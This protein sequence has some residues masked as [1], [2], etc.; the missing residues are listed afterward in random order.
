M[1][2]IITPTF[3]R[4]AV[5]DFKA[6]VDNEANNYYIGIGKLTP[7]P[8]NPGE[9]GQ[10][11]VGEE[12]STFV[13]PLP[14]VTLN[15]EKDVRDEL[16]T[17]VKVSTDD[18]RAMIPKNQWKPNRKYKRY[19]PT[20]PLTFEYEG[21][22]FPCVSV[23][24]DRIY[25]CVAN[26][27]QQVAP[28]LNG[29]PADSLRAP[30]YDNIT[31]QNN[32]V[33]GNPANRVSIEDDNGYMWAYLGDLKSNSK[34]DNDQFVG[35]PDVLIDT[36]QNESRATAAKAA[37][38]GLIYGF[39]VIET[40]NQIP[41]TVDLVIEGVGEDGNALPN[42]DIIINGQ[43]QSPFVVN[44]LAAGGSSINEIKYSG[45]LRAAPLGYAKATVTAYGD[46]NDI[47]TKIDDVQIIPLLAPIEGFGYDVRTTTPAHFV[48]LY[49]RFA[50]SVDGEALTTVAYRPSQTQLCV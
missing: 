27:A 13:E 45:S 39:K 33:N 15:E 5:S 9:Q 7:W 21:Q 43:V 25:L 50:E 48:G 17:L 11:S 2:A 26:G 3:R 6:G 44:G 30:D 35:I 20:D 22:F 28:G 47:T 41:T 42:T 38:G 18:V 23:S 34:L 32:G 31:F 46:K 12:S 29:T 16:M 49:T 37:T 19:D 8:N 10:P 1:S 40:S 14:Q 4:N 24:N 36:E